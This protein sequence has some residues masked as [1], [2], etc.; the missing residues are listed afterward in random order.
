MVFVQLIHVCDTSAQTGHI[1]NHSNTSNKRY[2]IIL[3]FYSKY[4]QLHRVFWLGRRLTSFVATDSGQWPASI[5][6]KC[7]PSFCSLYIQLLPGSKKY[8]FT[9]PILILVPESTEFSFE[10]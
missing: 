8:I 6:L 10:M 5:A 7:Q 3:T 4:Q 9:L 2:V 1:L